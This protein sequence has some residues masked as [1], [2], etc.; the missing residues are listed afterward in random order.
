MKTIINF[1][2]IIIGLLLINYSLSNKN[3]LT[4][5]IG[6]IIIILAYILSIETGNSYS[7]FNQPF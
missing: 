4:L 5:I 6:I 3:K 1:I 2:A 7:L